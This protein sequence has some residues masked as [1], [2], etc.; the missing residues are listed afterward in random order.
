[1]KKLYTL[2]I[3][4]FLA[5]EGNADNIIGNSNLHLSSQKD[6]VV[7]DSLDTVIMTLMKKRQIPGLSL[8]VIQDGKIVKAKGYGFVDKNGS[9]PIT[10]STLFQAG[11]ISKSVAATGAL[12]LVENNKLALDEDV[13]TKLQTWKVPENEFTKNKK[14]TLRGLLSHTAGL[15]VHGFPGYDIAGSIPTVAQI[16]DGTAP[17]N[18]PAVRVNFVPGSEWRYSGGGYTVMQQLMIDVT[19]KLFPDL[20]QEAVLKPLHMTAST[21]EQPLPADK[22]KL[23]ATAHTG[24]RAMVEGRWHVYPEMAAAGLWTTASDLARFAISIQNGVTGK[25]GS[26][27]SQSMTQQMLTNQKNNDGLGV[28]LQGEGATR[29]FHHGGRDEGFDALMIAGAERGQGVVIMINAND[30]SR[31][32]N[33]IVNAVAT[34]YHWNGFP[35]NKPVQRIAANVSQAQLASFEGRYELENNFMITLQSENGRL[36]SLS[37]NLPDEELVPLSATQFGSVDRDVIISFSP[38]SKGQVTGFTLQSEDEKREIPRIGPLFQSPKPASDPDAARTKRIE[39]ALN[40]MSKG[41]KVL[42]EAPGIAKG[43]RT[44]FKEG[45][46]DLSGIK[47]ILF[48]HSEN[49]AGRKIQRHGS[50]ISEIVTYRATSDKPDRYVIIHLTADGLVADC[51]VVSK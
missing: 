7:A 10:E 14:V 13:N 6:K 42:E 27:L 48:V 51:D 30:N 50:D 40:A 12:Y 31:M 49:V 20:M 36:F 26:I 35:V 19:T 44:A 8:A 11:S 24:D 21:F 37:D 2:T 41:G 34:H 23:T 16:L 1:M 15:T 9:S 38:D 29:T 28:F 5:I 22:A 25:S 3:L 46:R 47:S 33:Q 32:M 43:T 45:T 17:G 18:T 4:A 39:P